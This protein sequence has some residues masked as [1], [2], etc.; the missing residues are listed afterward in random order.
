[1]TVKW[2]PWAWSSLET[3]T[4]S[5]LRDHRPFRAS[6]ISWAEALTAIGPAAGGEGGE[7]RRYA[8]DDPAGGSEESANTRKHSGAKVRRS[9]APLAS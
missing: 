6:R 9:D 7:T 5:G 4:R 2:A 3:C 1:M 8:G